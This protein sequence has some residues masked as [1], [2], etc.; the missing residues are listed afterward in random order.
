MLRIHIV[1]FW[2]RKKLRLKFLVNSILEIFYVDLAR[3]SNGE[4]RPSA[5]FDRAD[6][7]L[8]F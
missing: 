7:R 4:I 2:N 3:D 5:D 6:L 8:K 1:Q